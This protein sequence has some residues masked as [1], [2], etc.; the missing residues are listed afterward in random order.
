MAT[1][2]QIKK[3]NFVIDRDRGW[4]RFQKEVKKFE[5][6]FT[7]VG[8]QAGERRKDD[9]ADM[10]LIAAVQE[11]G[12][13]IDVTPA[14]RKYLHSIGLHLKTS[15]KTI[16]IPERSFIRTPMDDNRDKIQKVI[17]KLYGQ[18]TEGIINSDGAR[19]PMTAEKAIAVLGEF[20]EGIIKKAIT[21]I[22]T[23]ANNPFTIARKGSSNPL[24]DKGQLR[25]SIRHEDH[26]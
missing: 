20:A 23:P 16:K 2:G 10:V 5:G 1:Q 14:M 17:N 11:F 26:V 8:V 7:K 22:D 6:A 9:Q 12:A 18:V 15:T 19:V 24:I 25:Q 21:D 4:D 13:V 3:E